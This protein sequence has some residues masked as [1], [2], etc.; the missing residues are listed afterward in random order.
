MSP[1]QFKY[2]LRVDGFRI[3]DFDADERLSFVQIRNVK[4]Q[5][6]RHHGISPAGIT[7]REAQATI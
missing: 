4:E 5:Y 7:I 1:E 2:T 3:G 6:A